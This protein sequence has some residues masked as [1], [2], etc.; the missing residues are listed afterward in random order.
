MF[1]TNVYISY[2]RNGSHRHDMERRGTVKYLAAT[3]MMELWAGARTRAAERLLRVIL[4]PYMAG[5][6]V[7]ALNIKSHVA[8]GRFLAS[9]RAE[10]GSLLKHAGF[11]ND[12][13][14]AYEALS[15]GAIIHTEDRGHFEI[16]KER[17]PSL[18]LEFL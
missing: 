12:L 5:D 16:I 14:L 4:T 8:M 9:M 17:L 11:L 6:R 18:K 2:I 13:R 15:V 3:V 7:V 10:H 1:D